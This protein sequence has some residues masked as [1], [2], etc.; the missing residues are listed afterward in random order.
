MASIFSLLC[1]LLIFLSPNTTVFAEGEANQ[2]EIDRQSLLCFKSGIYYDP[3]RV[4][5]SWRN[6]SPNFCNWSGVTCG[7]RVP[8]R[9]VSLDLASARLGGQISS[10]IAKL[11]SLSQ[12]NLTDN[13]LSGAI[14]DELGNLSGLQ[15]LML[16]FN[17]LEGNIPD[18]LGTA[19]S[20]SYV[21]LANN[22]LSGAIPHSLAS[23]SSLSKLILSHN[24]LT[25]GIPAPLFANSSRLTMVDLQM[26][27]LTGVI[28][29]F[30][31]VTALNYL[32]ISENFLSGSIPPSIGN[33]SSLHTLFLSQNKLTGLIPE[34]LSR[35]PK[36]LKLDLSINSLYGHVP[37]SLCNMSSL[38]S[39]QLGSNQISGSIPFE[40]SN[41][42]NLTLLSME[43]NFLSGSIPSTIGKLQNLFMLNLS[44][45]TISGQIPSSV[46]NITQLGKLFLGD[47]DLSGNIPGS[48]G[49]CLQLLQLNLSSNSLDGFL[50]KELFA[51]PHIPLGLDLSHNN[52][53]GEIPVDIG[54]LGYIIL[55]KLSNNLFSGGL[56]S[57]FSALQ[58]IEYINLSRNNL[59][60]IIPAFFEGLTMLEQ[61]DLSYNNFEGPIPISSFF[62]NSTMVHL[63]GNKRLCSSNFSM[64]ALPHCVGTD[65]KTK[66]H[67]PFLPVVVPT[68]CVVFLLLVF[69]LFALA[70]KLEVHR[71]TLH[72]KAGNLLHLVT[73]WRVEETYIFPQLCTVRNIL[74]CHALG[75]TR[76]VEIC[77]SYQE[78][79]KKVSYGDIA[80]ATNW[81]SPVHR[82]SSTRTGSV[83]V[84]RFKFDNDLVAIKVFNLI[85][86]G[87]HDSYLTECEVLRIIRHRNILKSVTLC[88]TLDTDKNEFKALIFQF[89]ANGSLERW[90][91]PNRQTDRPMRT[92]SLGQRICIVT[93]VAFALDYLHNQLTPPLVHCDLKPSN[94]LLDYDMTARVGDFG[95]AKFLS[96]DSSNL[97]HS[98]SIQGTIGYLAPDYGMGCGISTMV[99]VYSFGV[100]LLEMLTGKRPTDEMFVDGLSL[101]NF[102]ESMFPDRVAEI[103]DPSMAHLD[104][105]LFTELWIQSYIIPLVGIGLSC[106]MG[107]PKG[108]P[109][110]HDVCTKLCAI[111]EAFLESYGNAFK[112]L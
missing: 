112:S 103:L 110:M 94:V 39:L 84:G 73:H 92:L 66:K 50:P 59:S 62:A 20:L 28:P 75:R 95:S 21:N 14:P 111:Q 81:F 38:E 90:L 52:L 60:G 80:K 8:N 89:M 23:S 105:K 91:H 42:V 63:D 100:L 40:I 109:G 17:R 58:S 77:P 97:N 48:L 6:T 9:V 67:V 86:R 18:S 1:Y 43:N 87:A 36:L 41:F 31:K 51:G 45:N 56:P 65:T 35:I 13:L 27:S 16:A 85:E 83:Y 107:S 53:I 15:T 72:S 12:I 79:L 25:G 106:S 108:R 29:P 46:G 93:D 104:H 99:D 101:H 5:N 61:L 7:T 82:I 32:C 30:G 3:L 37:L 76:D 102:T 22:N 2:S 96:R 57:S 71:P 78:T 74:C 68:V 4:L 11:T 33:V 47:N 98:E 54:R 49:L 70:K 88:S 55:L 24:N 10:C 69:S 34:S 44:N 19:M 26:N 64:L